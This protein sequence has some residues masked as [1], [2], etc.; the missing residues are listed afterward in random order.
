MSVLGSH[1]EVLDGGASFAIHLYPK[2]SANVLN[3]LTESTIVWYHYI[4]LLLGV[5]VV[6]VYWRLFSIWIVC[7]LLNSIES[8]CGVFTV[9]KCIL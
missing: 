7:F 3:A 5:V 8:S 9:L 6:S 1:Q 4:R 2:L